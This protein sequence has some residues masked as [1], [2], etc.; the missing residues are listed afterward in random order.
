MVWACIRLA[1][2]CE[3]SV[4]DHAAVRL[5]CRNSSLC[6]TCSVY[7][8]C[9]LCPGGTMVMRS[10]RLQRGHATMLTVSMFAAVGL[11]GG[12]RDNTGVLTTEKVRIQ[13]ISDSAAY[14]VASVVARDMNFKAYTNRAMVANQVAVAQLVGLA[15]W[16]KMLRNAGQ[17]FNRVTTPLQAIPYVGAVIRILGQIIEQS[18]RYFD[19]AISR[20]MPALILAEEAVLTAISG[21]QIA[22][23]GVTVGLAQAALED[24]VTGSDPSINT[25]SIVTNTAMWTSFF[26]AWGGK[27]ELIRPPQRT[28]GTATSRRAR[29]RMEEFRV[30]TEQ[31][32]DGFS[33][34]RTYNW[35]EV[36]W[37]WPA[38]FRIRKF[39]GSDLMPNPTTDRQFNFNW[40]AMDVVGVET[41]TWRFL[42]GWSSWRETLP[43]GYGAA[44]ALTQGSF[45]NYRANWNQRRDN[46][47]VWG[48]GVRSM[49]M[50]A[51]IAQARYGNNNLRRSFGLRPFFDLRDRGRVAVGDLNVKIL[52]TKGD[53]D[54]DAW[55]NAITR[56][57]GGVTGAFNTREHGGL[58]GGRMAA[59]A[60]AGVYFSRDHDPH[61]RPSNRR[62]D[63]NLA[64]TSAG[65]R[66]DFGDLYNPYWQVRL[67]PPTTAERTLALAAVGVNL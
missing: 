52:L 11:A 37:L 44:H 33:R 38:Q 21:A 18:T 64:G 27:Q 6:K 26:N 58:A 7:K 43:F 15:S 2:Q 22:H 23:H 29:E 31:S 54:L 13:T 59:L 25:A 36:S 55:E 65:R 46:Q 63:I 28:S 1:E 60:K 32:R 10:L 3:S 17:N 24:V 35:F 49:P 67:L 57:G 8:T 39:G 14:S 48:N 56:A 51:G 19:E 45:Y 47:Y 40:T 4:A 12:G 41:R 9:N 30:V 34:H 62:N 61:Y 53:G 20:I 16:S 5:R 50:N 66:R 42:R